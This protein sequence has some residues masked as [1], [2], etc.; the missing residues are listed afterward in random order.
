MKQAYIGAVIVTFNPD[1]ARLRHV[2]AATA[3]QVGEIVLVDNGSTTDAAADLTGVSPNPLG[4]SRW[5]TTTASLRR[6][7]ALLVPAARAPGFGTLA[8]LVIIAYVLD[9]TAASVPVRTATPS[10][11]SSSSA[12]SRRSAWAVRST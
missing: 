7:V 11:P 4:C 6:R 8:N 3:R 9:L 1:P 12:R 10:R 5:A 2:V